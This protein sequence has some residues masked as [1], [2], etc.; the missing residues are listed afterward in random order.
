MFG[1]RL[2]SRTFIRARRVGEDI[3][4]LGS[5]RR[6]VAAIEFAFF[7][8]LLSIGMLNV[9]DVSIFAFQ[10]MEVNN[11]T[12][13]GAQAAWATCS[14]SLPSNA[15]AQLPATLNSNCPN[16]NTKVT[17]AVQSTSLG[18][19]VTL[20]SGSP[21]EGYYCINASNALVYVSSVRSKPADCSSVG[22]A[23][24]QPA[25]YIKVQTTF[26]YTP[27]FKGITV[28][29]LLPTTIISTALMRLG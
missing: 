2:R 10:R 13:V 18:T 27:L 19:N 11:A 12:E 3:K 21:A 15:T 6:G 1:S 9:V 16:L 29:N 17:A 23:A 22:N 20:Q 24:L 8:S 26:T 14:P 5:D 7:G 4:A 28:G 25:D